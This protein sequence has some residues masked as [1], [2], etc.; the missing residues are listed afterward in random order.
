MKR[1][2]WPPLDQT[3]AYFFVKDHNG[4]ARGRSPAEEVPPRSRSSPSTS[5]GSNAQRKAALTASSR[6]DRFEPEHERA[7]AA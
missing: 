6:A 3:D 2:F 5:I 1:R 4:Q 7:R